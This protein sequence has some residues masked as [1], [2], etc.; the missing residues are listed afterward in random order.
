MYK[1]DRNYKQE[2]ILP[3][4]RETAPTASG[5]YKVLER[6]SSL[7]LVNFY[8]PVDNFEVSRFFKSVFQNVDKDK[9]QI[10]H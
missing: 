1:L 4:L 8:L 10:Y 6:I 5:K 7:I 9:F 3:R 2:Q